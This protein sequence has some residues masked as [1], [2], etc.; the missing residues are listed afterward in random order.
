MVFCVLL[1]L[2]VLLAAMCFCLVYFVDLYF[3]VTTIPFLVL[4]RFLVMFSS[5]EVCSREYITGDF[6]TRFTIFCPRKARQQ[7]EGRSRPMK[8]SESGIQPNY[9]AQIWSTQ[10]DMIWLTEVYSPLG[11]FDCANLLYILLVVI[12]MI[13]QFALRSPVISWPTPADVS[14]NAPTVARTGRGAGCTIS[15][16]APL[17]AHMW[18]DALMFGRFFSYIIGSSASYYIWIIHICIT[19]VFPS[20]FLGRRI[21]PWAHCSQGLL[22]PLDAAVER[23][24]SRSCL[25]EL[26]RC[27]CPISQPLGKE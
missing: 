3:M 14:R 6:T 10:F 4:R 1:Q 22:A 17:G 7:D 26:D 5:H 13:P 16:V 25:A 15:P 2:L 11:S 8:P 24:S 27:K 18:H 21:V 9:V 19:Q 23:W 20:H 12:H